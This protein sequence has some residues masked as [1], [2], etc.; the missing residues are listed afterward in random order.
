MSV[1]FKEKCTLGGGWSLEVSTADIL[2]GHIRRRPDTGAYRYFRGPVNELNH[3]FED[4]DLDRL[5]VQ[6]SSNP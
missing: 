3:A 6:V 5:K 2:R 1:T 4:A